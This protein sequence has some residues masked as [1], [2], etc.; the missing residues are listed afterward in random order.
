M[1]IQKQKISK[2]LNQEDKF[3]LINL[4][5]EICKRNNVGLP[6]EKQRIKYSLDQIKIIKKISKF[7]VWFEKN[8]CKN[9]RTKKETIKLIEI[10]ID[11]LKKNITI[12]FYALFCPSY[13]K[14]KQIHGFETKIGETS[15]R[16]IINLYKIFKKAKSLGFNCKAKA[17]F[18]DLAL[19][20]FNKLNE[21]DFLDLETNYKKLIKYCKETKLNDIQFFKLSDIGNAKK[22]ITRKGIISGKNFISKK[23]IYRI[24]KRSLPFYEKILGWNKKNIIKRTEELSKSCLVM[25]KEIE[26]EN[27]LSIMVMIENNYE[28]GIFYNPPNIKSTP[29]FYPKKIR[30]IR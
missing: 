4:V 14:G 11:S 16:G 29:I 27:P 23:Q 12:L 19:E 9:F 18:S 24:F 30:T 1:I 26:K 2:F 22:K 3:K 7:L 13:K 21:D 5:V 15:K 8:E 28:R 17:I 10:L 20:N 6:K 25:K